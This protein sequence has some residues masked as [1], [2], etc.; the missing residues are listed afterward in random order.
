[1]FKKL[2]TIVALTMAIAL[3][4]TAQDF[5]GNADID[6]ANKLW[7]ALETARLVGP[8]R[9]NV[10]PFEGNEPHGAI[11]Q[12]YATT[13]AVG[14]RVA[15]VLVKANHGG[16]GIDV[17]AVYDNP[18]KHLGAYTVMFKREA[19]YDPENQDW[20]WA[21]YNP[22]G[23]LDKNPKGAAIAGKFMKGKDK[24]CIA[25]HTATGGDDLETLTSK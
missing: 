1:M 15:R 20:F 12:A 24:G 2:G 13:V 19:G 9:I 4:A 5:G 21:K 22:S 18:N 8:D 16:P 14:G 10:Q 23:Q 11:Q 7:S 25:C 3:P 17:S 6:F